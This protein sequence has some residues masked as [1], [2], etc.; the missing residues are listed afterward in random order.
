M[1]VSIDIT[2][3]KAAEEAVRVGQARLQAAAELA[4]LGFYEA[5]YGERAAFFDAGLRDILGLPPELNQGLQPVE[6]YLQGRA[7][8]G[9]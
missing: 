5:D 3:R 1:G 6:F 2:D 8:R 9:P 7:R 4:G